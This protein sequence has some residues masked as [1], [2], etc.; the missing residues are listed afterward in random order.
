MSAAAASRVLASSRRSCVSS[1][2]RRARRDRADGS[3]S[4]KAGN[5][6]S[7]STNSRIAALE[8]TLGGAVSSSFSQVTQRF[9]NP[10]RV[11]PKLVRR[12]DSPSAKES[13]KCR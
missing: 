8:V 4:N 1:Q 13:V 11:I 7:A 5:S 12:R 3:L 9:D 6:P 2:V 10:A